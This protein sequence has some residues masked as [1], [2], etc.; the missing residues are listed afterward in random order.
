MFTLHDDRL[1]RPTPITQRVLSV[2]RNLPVERRAGLPPDLPLY[3][4][5]LAPGA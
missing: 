2:I 4:T 5:V 1:V 3:L